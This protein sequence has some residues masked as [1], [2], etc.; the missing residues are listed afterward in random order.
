MSNE[1]RD[2]SEQRRVERFWIADYSSLPDLSTVLSSHL[3]DI[4]SLP[5]ATNRRNRLQGITEVQDTQTGQKVKLIHRHKIVT[6]VHIETPAAED[7]PRKSLKINFANH[8]DDATGGY[9]KGH[10][11]HA[12]IYENRKEEDSYPASLISQLSEQDHDMLLTA[13]SFLKTSIQ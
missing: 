8:F 7:N 13:V 6:A 11:A 10:V 4:S 9:T 3:D 5:N 12:E 1:T 2:R